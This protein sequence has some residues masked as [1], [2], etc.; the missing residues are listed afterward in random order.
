MNWLDP[1]MLLVPVG[2]LVVLLLGWWLSRFARSIHL[3]RARETFRLQH[4]RLEEHFLEAAQQNDKPRGLRWIG[5]EFTGEPELARDLNSRQLVAFVPVTIRFEA[6]EGSDMEELPA[7]NLP[8]S[9]SALF[10]FE[11]GQWLTSGQ[12]IFNLEP[13]DAIRR[14]ARQYA[15]VPT[16][17]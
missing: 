11:R 9:A 13:S 3:E 15:P 4:K 7:V 16:G 14:F 5:C 17:H 2:G 10:V 12:V 6:V 1:W 8:R